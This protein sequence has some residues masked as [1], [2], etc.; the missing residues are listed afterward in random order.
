MGKLL[1]NDII[2]IRKYT[3]TLWIVLIYLLSGFEIFGQTIVC[4]IHSSELELLAAKEV[5]RY[6]YLRTGILLK[7]EKTNT[8]PAN[9]ELIIVAEDSDSLVDTVTSFDAPHGGFFIKSIA[10][11]D[12]NIL[13]ISGDEAASTLFGAYRFAEK[14]GCRFYFHGDVIPDSKIELTLTGY[15][16]KG[17]PVTKNRRQWTTRGIQPFQNFPAGAVMWGEDDWKMYITQLPK[18]GMNFVGLH[19]YMYDPEDDHVGD[20]GPNL[21]IWLGH[22]D[23]LNADGTVNFAFDAT[24]FHTHQ[25]IIGWGKTNTSDLVGGTSQLFPTDGYPS[26]IIGETY[27]HDQSGYTHS[28]DKA[29]DLFSDVFTLAKKLNIITATG[30]EIPVGKDGETGEEPIVNGIPEVLQNRLRNKYGIDPLSQ[31]AAEELFK[32]AYKWLLNNK[33]PV[34]YFWM[35][36]T[37]IWMPWGGASLDSVRIATAKATIQAAEDVYHKMPQKPFDH[38]ALGGWITGAQGQPDVFGD[39]LPDLNDAYAF[40]NPPYNLAGKRM[41]TEEWIDKIPTQRVKWSFTWMEYDYALEQPSFHMNRIYRDARD[42]YEQNADGF[43]GEFWR[44]KMIAP[45]FAAFKDA[46]WDYASSGGIIKQDIPSD[47][48]GR[49]AKIDSVHLDWAT[50]EFGSGPAAEFIASYFAAFEKRDK[51]RFKNVMNFIEG[52]DNIYSQGFI[53]GDDWGSDHIWG[54]WENEKDWFNWIDKWRAMRGEI[55]GAGNIARFDYWSN[56]LKAHKLMV[57]F[58]CELNQ[59]EAETNA[60]NLAAASTHRSNLARLWENIMST[61]VQ[62]V[63][64]EVDLGVI[65][66]LDWRTWKNWVEGKYD[67]NFVK[68]GGKLPADKDPS[69]KYTGGKFITCMPLLTLV[70]PNEPT[71]IKA[72]IMG[73][74]TNPELHYRTLGDNSFTTIKLEHEAR[75]V[76]RGVIPGQLEDFEW[77]VTAITSLGDVVFPATAAA[78]DVERMYQT[79]VVNDLSDK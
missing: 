39:V 69:Q 38:F 1:I 58:A 35:W 36:T 67:K 20:Y 3:I 53:K 47:R 4:P 26:E 63:Y 76:Y 64:D 8:L 43:L 37:E 51:K 52:A 70:K 68:D 28:F 14:L 48:A 44:T 32:G 54:K 31:I 33:I 65:I 6:I 57:H 22:E 7:V 75:G 74:V 45:M 19:T 23:D 13:V 42:A 78:A 40:M 55:K 66:N 56:V 9:G 34:D 27:H 17:Q 16:E 18:M 12:R 21:N 41:K 10:K 79:V 2:G 77:Y 5:R 15:D 60:G 73:E 50:H 46:T 49:F 11:G 24:F 61:E 62:R 71:N 25:G 30:I 72:L 59:Y 29:A